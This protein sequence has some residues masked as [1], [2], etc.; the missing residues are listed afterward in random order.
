MGGDDQRRARGRVWLAGCFLTLHLLP[1][2]LGEFANPLATDRRDGEDRFTEAFA[3]VIEEDGLLV[4]VDFVGHDDLRLVRQNVTVLLEFPA[5]RVI[6]IHRVAA[7]RRFDVEQ[8]GEGRD[9]IDD[10]ESLL[11]GLAADVLSAIN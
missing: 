6:V 10:F 5:N 4:E 1:E 8:V 9:E 2:V 11:G 3:Y 7:V